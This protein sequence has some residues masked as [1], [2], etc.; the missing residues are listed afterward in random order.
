MKEREG[1]VRFPPLCS[2]LGTSL[3]CAMVRWV[4]KHRTMERES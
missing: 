1:E 2:Q 3:V 4:K